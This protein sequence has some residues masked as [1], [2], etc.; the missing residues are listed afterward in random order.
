[1]VDNKA[2]KNIDSI[3]VI[4]ETL[5]PNEFAEAVVVVVSVVHVCDRRNNPTAN[6][7]VAKICAS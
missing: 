7:L 1:M 5:A 2:A 3:F 4:D 6:D